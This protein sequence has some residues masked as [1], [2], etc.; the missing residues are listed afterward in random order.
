MFRCLRFLMKLLT[1]KSGKRF[2]LAHG[3]AAAYP[4]S[5]AQGRRSDPVAAARRTT[6]RAGVCRSSGP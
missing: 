4:Q 6:F 5:V 2:C 3:T 1:D